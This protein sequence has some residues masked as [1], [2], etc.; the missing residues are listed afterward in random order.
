MA[1]LLYSASHIKLLVGRSLNIA[2]AEI[3]FQ[4]DLELRLHVIGELEKILVKLG[5]IVTIEYY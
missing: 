1:K 5:K 4:R 2:N 3:S